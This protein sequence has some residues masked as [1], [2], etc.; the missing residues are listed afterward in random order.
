MRRG[1][2]FSFITDHRKRLLKMM[3]NGSVCAEIGVWKGDFSQRILE[4]NNPSELHLIDPWMFQPSFP[5]RWYGGVKARSQSDMDDIFESVRERFA[6]SPEVSF[7]R[8]TAGEAHS[9]FPDDFFDWVYV[10]GSHDYD[11]VKSDLEI[12]F[13]KVKPDGFLTGDDYFLPCQETG[14]PA[15][16]KQAV[17]DFVKENQ[18]SIV[19]IIGGQF[20]IQ[21]N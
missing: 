5:S 19:K 12:Y 18:A 15:P 3:P 17:Q 14:G 7:H 11:S 2:F 6:G 10:D 20:I 1:G 9:E 4:I 8:K 13:P 21:K 16:V